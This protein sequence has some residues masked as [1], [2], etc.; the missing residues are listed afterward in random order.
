[1]TG[2]VTTQLTLAV[3]LVPGGGVS[4][5]AAVQTVQI[6]HNKHLPNYCHYIQ[7]ISIICYAPAQH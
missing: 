5:Q 2:S 3:E 7:L 6:V 1:M 4:T